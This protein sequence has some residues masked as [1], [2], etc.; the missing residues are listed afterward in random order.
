MKVGCNRKGKVESAHLLAQKVATGGK[1]FVGIN[2]LIESLVDETIV[3]ALGTKGVSYL[4][5]TPLFEAKLV[6]HEGSGKTR[7]IEESFA[8]Q[9]AHQAGSLR[10]SEAPGL[11]LCEDVARTAF[12]LATEGGSMI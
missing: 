11:C 2:L 12:A 3:D 4:D 10:L 9:I 8:R 5:S 7:L 1:I 6:A